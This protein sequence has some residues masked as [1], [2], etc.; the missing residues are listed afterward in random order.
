M[1]IA[2][3]Y[4]IWA[5]TYD[6]NLNKTRDLELV[7]GKS[8]LKDRQF[9]N[10]IELGCG[11]GKN[12]KWLV[13]KCNSLIGV[14]FS[15]EMLAKAK[16][17]IKSEKIK[18]LQADILKTWTFTNNSTDLITAS[19]VLEHIQNIDIIF[20]EVNKSLLLN[21]LFYICELHPFK[22]YVGSKARFEL[23]GKTQKLETYI[24]HISEYLK[25]KK[26]KS[27]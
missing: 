1:T 2:D 9:D 13:N 8:V 4:N 24:H 25:K 18:F 26:K 12:T 10:I 5:H 7:V 16:L 21:G 23:N 15:T 3:S 20:S 19:L 17:K 6:S 14:D 22:Q 11:T 27:F